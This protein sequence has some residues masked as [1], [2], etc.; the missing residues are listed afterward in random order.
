MNNVQFLKENAP[1]VL[2]S[3]EDLSIDVFK[4]KLG[5]QNVV[6]DGNDKLIDDAIL[7]H[8]TELLKNKE[9]FEKYCNVIL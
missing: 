3:F 2:K 6:K 4:L 8:V 9:D 7:W 1:E 5:L